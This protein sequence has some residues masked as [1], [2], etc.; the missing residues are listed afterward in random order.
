MSG[1]ETMK[2]FPRR[3]TH[4]AELTHEGLDRIACLFFACRN[5]SGRGGKSLSN[6]DGQWLAGDQ[7]RM[8][9]RGLSRDGHGVGWRLSRRTGD[10]MPSRLGAVA[11]AAFL[12]I[13]CAGVVPAS[14]QGQRTSLPGGVA[15][16]CQSV[17]LRN[18]PQWPTSGVWASERDLLLLD[19]MNQRTFTYRFDSL[20]GSVSPSQD[21]EGLRRALSDPAPDDL[22]G[23]L[24]GS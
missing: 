10:G 24:R 14:V 19:A 17:V 7:R 6:V 5:V 23:S 12:A 9:N 15:S 20:G 8:W 13:L 16:D 3:R 11:L 1:G 21:R 2:H 18:Q 22:T 4:E